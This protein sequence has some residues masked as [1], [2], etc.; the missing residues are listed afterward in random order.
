M[1]EV[2]KLIVCATIHSVFTSCS[3]VFLDIA[4]ILF[5]DQASP[6]VILLCTSCTGLLPRSSLERTLMSLKHKGF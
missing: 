2:E 3:T 4:S 1:R 6:Q 5:Y